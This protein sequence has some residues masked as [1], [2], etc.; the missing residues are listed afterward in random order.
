M[1]RNSDY[2]HANAEME[3]GAKMCHHS[4]LN[5][6]KCFATIK[7]RIPYGGLV[8]YSRKYHTRNLVR[9]VLHMES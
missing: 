2:R 4:R 1:K 5:R 3:E 9:H 7:D 6:R 8:L